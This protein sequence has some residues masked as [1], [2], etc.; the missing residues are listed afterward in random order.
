MGGFGSGR[1][2]GAGRNTVE[3]Y[4]A[5]DADRLHRAGCLRAGWAG[6]WQ[7]GVGDQG[8]SINL[9][10]EPDQLHLSYSVRVGGGEWE[11]VAEAVPL[12]RVP[13]RLSG[14]R[15]YF[16]CPG[17]VDGAACGRRLAGAARTV[18]SRAGRAHRGDAHV[19]G[20]GLRTHPASPNLHGGNTQMGNVGL[21]D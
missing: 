11:D 3:A 10:A 9:R 8:A 20:N 7:W 2:R 15:P 14:T 17:G 4:R 12:V 13:C 19:L 16:I 5:L 21:C 1:P 6:G 18:P